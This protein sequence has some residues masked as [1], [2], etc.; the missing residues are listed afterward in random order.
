MYK[1]GLECNIRENVPLTLFGAKNTAWFANGDGEGVCI[2]EL[3]LNLRNA[4][5]FWRQKI[6]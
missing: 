2:I 3:N 1:N 4:P 6:N 5:E